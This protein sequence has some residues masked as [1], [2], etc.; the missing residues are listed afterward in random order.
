VIPGQA[1][2]QLDTNINYLL[3]ESKGVVGQGVAGEVPELKLT[4]GCAIFLG[5]FVRGNAGGKKAYC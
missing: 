4:H 3:H 2:S 1:L 5:E